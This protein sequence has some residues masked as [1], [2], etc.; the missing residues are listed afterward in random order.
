[1][2]EHRSNPITEWST[3]RLCF[4]LCFS[5]RNTRCANRKGTANDC[6]RMGNIRDLHLW[7]KPNHSP[8]G[9]QVPRNHYPIKP[10]HSAPER[11]QRILLAFGGI[12][13]IAPR[14]MVLF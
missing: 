1:M 10:V 3:S 12:K 2:Y 11:H 6:I 4:L 13:A 9:P 14:Q 5:L 7:M 8:D